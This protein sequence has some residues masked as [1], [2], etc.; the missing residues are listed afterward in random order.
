[1]V[2]KNNR[3]HRWVINFIRLMGTNEACAITSNSTIFPVCAI[4]EIKS[5]NEW[6]RVHWIEIDKF[7]THVRK[8]RTKLVVTSYKKCR[9]NIWNLMIIRCCENH[10]TFSTSNWKFCKNTKWIFTHILHRGANWFL[11]E[12]WVL[13]QRSMNLNKNG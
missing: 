9:T 7:S 12:I 11:R 10:I 2:R 1:M 13:C 3:C 4:F 6:N 5:E 8:N